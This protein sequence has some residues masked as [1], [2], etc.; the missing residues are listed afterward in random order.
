MMPLRTNLRAFWRRLS[1]LDLVAFV[2][3]LVGGI[4]YLL[5]GRGSGL[6]FIKFLGAI[7]AISIV[8]R[9]IGWWR[10]RLLWR[11]RNRL[12]VAYLFIA[13]VPVLLV[14]ALAVFSGRILYTQLGGYLL[15]VDLQHR[16]EMVS[17]GVEQIAYAL[18]TLTRVVPLQ[19]A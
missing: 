2:L 13:L 16:V 9:M 18:D 15:Y 14:L 12:I 17:D 4:A 5:G 6:S 10:T 7:A 8:I 3:F 11:L 19:T 1:R